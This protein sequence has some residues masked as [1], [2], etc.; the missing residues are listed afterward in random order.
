MKTTRRATA[1][2]QLALLKFPLGR[3]LYALRRID[4]ALVA[5]GD[6]LLRARVARAL[7]LGEE[8]RELELQWRGHV[9][10]REHGKEARELDIELDRALS[11]LHGFLKSTIKGFGEGTPQGEAGKQL[12]ARLFPQGLR[13]LI[14]LPFVAEE[15]MVRHLLQRAR[16]EPAL[17]AAVRELGGEPLLERVTEAH[18][19]YALALGRRAANGPTFPQVRL[20]RREAQERLCEIQFLVFAELLRGGHGEAETAALWKAFDEVASQNQAI[21][22]YRR[23]RSR[24]PDVDPETGARID[25][26]AD[27]DA[28]GEEPQEPGAPAAH[29]IAQPI[30]PPADQDGAGA[31]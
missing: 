31:A 13:K 15:S 12:L 24:V 17:R 28:P 3:Q 29:P 4:E 21:R 6:A 8:A 25:V 5:S 16:T 9:R 22:R 2:E 30:A 20:A 23:R 18:A 10:A 19:R 7:R 26:D 14:H 27:D 1:S 11:A